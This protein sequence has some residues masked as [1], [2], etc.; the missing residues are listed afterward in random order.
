MT[1]T[2]RMVVGKIGELEVE[3]SAAATDILPGLVGFDDDR[4]HG[5]LNCLDEVCEAWLVGDGRDL[6][7]SRRLHL[8]C[9]YRS[10]S[11]QEGGTATK[12]DENGECGSPDPA[13][14]TGN[15]G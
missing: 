4:D 1:A 3:L 9:R 14:I 15:H 13:A 6:D 5:R 8:R 11:G 10:G 12:A 7:L 2:T